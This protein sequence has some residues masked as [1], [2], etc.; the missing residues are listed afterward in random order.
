MTATKQTR[1]EAFLAHYGVPGMRWGVRRNPSTG[2][3]T[4]TPTKGT[5]KAA[6]TDNNT[7]TG[8]KAPSEESN[9]TP[10]QGK[11]SL[12]PY[13]SGGK[14]I[15]IREMSDKELLDVVNRLNT[16]ARYTTL[17]KKPPSKGEKFV[18]EIGE[19][20]LKK[21]ATRVTNDLAAQAL[22]RLLD[23]KIKKKTS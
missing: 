16:E 18:K 13:R 9:S 19:S 20:V 7:Q 14:K 11:N 4:G 3:V 1:A 12:A 5:K 21:Q 8:K 2:R 15:N 23:K 6:R 17:T 10:P 22:D